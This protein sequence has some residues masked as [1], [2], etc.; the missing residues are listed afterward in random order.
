MALG[1]GSRWACRE[2]AHPRKLRATNGGTREV[3]KLRERSSA[4]NIF[5]GDY[6]LL[7]LIFGLTTV[8]GVAPQIGPLD[9]Y[10]RI[11]GKLVF[12][13]SFY[14]PGKRYK[15]S[16]IHTPLRLLTT[17]TRPRAETIVLARAR[18]QDGRL[19]RQWCSRQSKGNCPRKTRSPRET[20]RA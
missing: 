1:S 13:F 20:P 3:N 10:V 17:A 4:R 2:E 6:K 5:F 18:A 12:S 7:T 14:S 9:T 8:D 19:P 11:A 15:S 16:M